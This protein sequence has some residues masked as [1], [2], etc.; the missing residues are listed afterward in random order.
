MLVVAP[1]GGVAEEHATAPVGLQT[2]LMGIDDD[3]VGL[4]DGRIS[5]ASGLVESAGDEG[6]VASVSRVHV[7]SETVSLSESENC[8]ERVY[9]ANGRGAK[10]D[11]HR[12]H[13]TA[14]QLGLQSS[15]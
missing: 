11:Y 4:G 12:A 14:S 1:D 2:M 3:G 13:I 6:K 5:Q 15:N 8:V 9:G 10:R 7:D